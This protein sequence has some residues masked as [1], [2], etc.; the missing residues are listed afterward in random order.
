MSEETT[1]E[2]PATEAPAVTVN[3]LANAYAVI[4]LA[5]KRG[6]FQAAELSAVGAVANKI[7]AFIDFVQAAQ[8]E[9]ADDQSGEDAPAEG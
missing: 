2:A 4:D 1:V 7:K 3:D 9:A 6:A 5:S 8:A